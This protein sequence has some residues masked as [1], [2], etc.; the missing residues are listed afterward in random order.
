MLFTDEEFAQ[1]KRE[2]VIEGGLSEV[3]ETSLIWPLKL[4]ESDGNDLC[5]YV[6]GGETGVMVFQRRFESLFR[7]VARRLNEDFNG[8]I[9]V[10]YKTGG[11]VMTS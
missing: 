4:G 9:T 2:V 8:E 3:V 1:L 10:Q 5:I 6:P 7:K 11:K